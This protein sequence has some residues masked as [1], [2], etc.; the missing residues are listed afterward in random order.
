M[1]PEDCMIPQGGI[2]RTLTNKLLGRAGKMFKDR[3][4][5]W[6]YECLGNGEI[7]I[8]FMGGDA[9]R[10]AYKFFIDA[11]AADGIIPPEAERERLSPTFGRV[12]EAYAH[13]CTVVPK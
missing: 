12:R 2:Q 7:S 11:A 4:N 13:T 10:D 3:C 1:V 9:A 8:L 6:T 5:E